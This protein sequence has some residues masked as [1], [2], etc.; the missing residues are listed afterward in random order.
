MRA[1]KE[2]PAPLQRGQVLW[3]LEILKVCADKI[4]EFFPV[5]RGQAVDLCQRVDELVFR[6]RRR[7]TLEKINALHGGHRRCCRW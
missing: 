5:F 7:A 6:R 3:L 4:D 2:S 1:N